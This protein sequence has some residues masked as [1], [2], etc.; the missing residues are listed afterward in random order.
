MVSTRKNTYDVAIIGAGILGPALATT[1]AKDGRSVLLVERDLSEPDRIVGELLQPGGVEALE[2]LGLRDCL[3][4]ID[5]VP[6]YGYE[7]IY[8][9][10]RVH[11]PYPKKD[12][13]DEKP[14][15]G[16]SFHHGRFVM[17]LRDA[18]RKTAGVTLIEAT[19]KD[20]IRDEVNGGKVLGLVARR[21]GSETDEHFFASLTVAADG[22]TSNFRK[23]TV[24]EKPFA[25][26]SFY[27]LELID[28]DMP[29]PYHGHV[30]LGDN[31]PVLLYQIGTH[32]TRALVDIAGKMPIGKLRNHMLNV[33]LPS[34][35]DSL[36][37]SFR[38]AVENAKRFPSMPNNFLRPTKNTTPGFLL[39]GD[40]MNMRHP[41]TG[42]GM[43][44]AFTD[45]VLLGKLLS[46]DEVPDLAD[47]DAVLSQLSTFHWARKNQGSSTINIL[48][49]A[50]YALFAADDD[51]LRV[52]QKGCFGY[53]KRGGDCVTGPVSLLAGIV[54]QPFVLFYH[55]YAVALYSIW[56][57]LKDM[58]PFMWPLGIMRAFAVFWKACVVIFPYIF[59]ELKA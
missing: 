52:L 42:G 8:H 16:R 27:A 39:I 6:V 37:P 15:Q 22:C 45:A 1:F 17:K 24:T 14:R 31:K 46:R 2:T 32:E 21:K 9:G 43:T 48:S 47:T 26:S 35:P 30:L 20:L 28:A 57:M 54:G 25:S 5:A 51:R 49:M 12:E 19:A 59:S 18:A 23:H 34:L 11:I 40:A 13:E 38:R 50:L 41:L 33:V 55:F 4:G 10:K 53:F 56:L 36:W 29:R 58:E 7:V 3:D 44:V